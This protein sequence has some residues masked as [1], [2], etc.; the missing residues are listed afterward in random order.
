MGSFLRCQITFLEWR[1]DYD[2]G[3]C[4]ERLVI[5]QSACKKKMQL[6]PR[7]GYILEHSQAWLNLLSGLRGLKTVR[8]RTGALNQT[9]PPGVGQV[10]GSLTQLL[11][12]G[13]SPAQQAE[14]SFQERGKRPGQQSISEGLPGGS[15][16]DR[17]VQPRM[18]DHGN[19]NL[20]GP[21]WMSL[22]KGFMLRFLL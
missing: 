15:S 21:P 3:P 20:Q 8:R 2:K 13:R 6:I 16:W 5:G 14:F 1:L 12:L 11:M 9:F 4:H 22:S 18:V 19:P 17:T 10:V 7:L